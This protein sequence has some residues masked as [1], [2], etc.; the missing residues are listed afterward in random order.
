MNRFLKLTSLLLAIG[1]VGACTFSRATP[2]PVTPTAPAATPSRFS[3]N[4]TTTLKSLKKVDDHPLYTMQ[5]FGEY[6]PRETSV[7][8]SPG[9]ARPTPGWACSLFTVLL[10]E[11]HHLYGRNFD[12]QYSPALLLFTDPPDGYASV[13]MVDMEYLGFSGQTFLNL[14]DLPLEDI[15]E[16]LYAPYLPFDGMNDHGLAIGMAAVPDGNMQA[17]PSRETIGSLGIMREILDHARDVDEAVGILKIYNIDFEGGPPLHYL[18]ADAK[19]KAVLVEFQRGEMNLIWNEGPWHFATNFLRSSVQDPRDG[20]CWRYN[21]MD[22]RL[23]EKQG[24]LDA[25]SAMQLLADVAQ[26]NTQWSVVYQ[27]ALDEVSIAMGGDYSEI[28]TF[29]VSDFWSP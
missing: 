1:A 28:H 18:I 12:W 11:E 5:Y 2:I 14:T 3:E 29:D 19:G 16:L 24:L 7:L 21:R 9:K 10:D 22:A 27:M 23:E 17:D 6:T 26:E 25:I 8:P 20:Y 15:E 4:E 13:S